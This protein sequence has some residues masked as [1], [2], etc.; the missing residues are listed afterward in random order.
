MVG[1][2]DQKEYP[3]KTITPKIIYANLIHAQST[4]HVYQE[5][6]GLE[7]RT[8]GLIDWD[9][10]WN[11][12]HKQFFT[13]DLKS[14][15]WSQ[16]HL[17]F[18]TTYNYNKWKNTLNP[19]PLC[20]KIPEDVFHVIFDCRFTK[21][22]WNR[23]EKIL[24]KIHPKSVTPYEKAFGLQPTN[25][26]EENP[27][28]LRNWITYNVRHFLLLEERIAYHKKSLPIVKNFFNKFN[29]RTQDELR[30]KK[31]LF[32]LQELSTKFEEIITINNAVSV[33]RNGEYQW[34]PIM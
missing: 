1:L 7:K 3:F 19:C 23:I 10:V 13:E 18:Y 21:L 27:L 16:L 14:T 12:V 24:L 8:L 32:D 31:I 22:V 33:K 11:S 30:T 20:R 9:K 4:D 6:W 5:K 26:K 2:Y 34:K 28:I 17:N 25:N 15:I 29:L